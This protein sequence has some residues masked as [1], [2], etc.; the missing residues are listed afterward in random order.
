MFSTPLCADAPAL[1]PKHALFV[2]I[3]E[4]F[5]HAQAAPLLCAGAAAFRALCLT[6]LEDGERLGL[7]GFGESAHLVRQWSNPRTWCASGQTS[8]PPV[9]GLRVHG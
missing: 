6:G 2:A 3:P 4:V 9:A 7:T 5:G 8:L 1:R